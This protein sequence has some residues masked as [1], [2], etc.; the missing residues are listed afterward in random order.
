M[1]QC[2]CLTGVQSRAGGTAGGCGSACLP[3]N[4]H[5]AF[6]PLHNLSL[7]HPPLLSSFYAT[8]GREYVTPGTWESRKSFLAMASG[9][10]SIP[11]QGRPQPLLGMLI[12]ETARIDSPASCSPQTEQG[13]RLTSTFAPYIQMEVAVPF[14]AAGDCLQGVRE[15]SQGMHACAAA[16]EEHA[17]GGRTQMPCIEGVGLRM[18]M[19]RCALARLAPS[20]AALP[21]LALQL[22]AE[23]YGPARLYEGFR[24][25]ALIRFIRCGQA[26]GGASPQRLGRLLPPA[27]AGTAPSTPAAAPCPALQRRGVLPVAQPR[28]RPPLGAHKPGGLVGTSAPAHLVACPT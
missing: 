10:G 12:Q 15:S 17:A 14:E 16:E 4:L 19:H 11:G 13:T 3:C 21:C 18:G 27:T 1:L 5:A 26:A 23:V 7:N 20:G 24:N 2:C 9:A 25:P 22:A 6:A 28:R 8:L